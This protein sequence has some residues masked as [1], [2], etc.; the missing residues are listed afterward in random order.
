MRLLRLCV[1]LHSHLNNLRLKTLKT[2]YCPYRKK[3]VAHNPEEDV[4][5]QLLKRMTEQLLY[6]AEYLVLEKELK[7]L[8]HLKDS[9]NIPSRRLDI[10]CFAKHPTTQ[11]LFP[12]L[13]VE[14]KAV[15]IQQEMFRQVTGYNHYVKALFI[16]IVNRA[17][18]RFGWYDTKKMA[19]VY[20][21][22]FPAFPDLLA[23]LK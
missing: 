6:P 8:P 4:R 2:L 20:T 1:E 18:C 13:L 19:Y 16:A 15:P 22:S 14:C 17:E 9:V 12:L 5:Q 7:L 3:T 10:V 11:N 23:S 21:S